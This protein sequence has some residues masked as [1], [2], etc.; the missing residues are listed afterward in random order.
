MMKSIATLV[1]A[2]AAGLL[3]ATTVNAAVLD[4][5]NATSGV[6]PGSLSCFP[7][8]CNFSVTNI[9]LPNTID[10]PNGGS[11]IF[12]FLSFNASSPAGA[13]VDFTFSVGAALN[14]LSPD[15]D[16]SS[17]G[18]PQTLFG[19]PIPTGTLFG[20]FLE[21]TVAWD[22]IAPVTI[23]GIGT[24]SVLFTSA[25]VGPFFPLLGPR[26]F[27]VNAEVSL[28]PIPLPGGILLLGS[29]MLGIF[30]L[31]RRRNRKLAAA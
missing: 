8:P 1:R 23:P 4:I 12:P 22:S 14:F 26:N 13:G 20:R 31:S 27:V 6:V 18:G 11:V 2:A 25:A 16:F 28:Q 24:L 30:G 3:L 21:G 5:D 17:A 7:A 9:A 19:F 29:A 10:V 15:Y